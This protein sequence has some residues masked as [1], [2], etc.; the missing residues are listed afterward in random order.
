MYNNQI[1]IS[2]K[3]IHLVL[4]PYT[5]NQVWKFLI[6]HLYLFFSLPSLTGIKKLIKPTEIDKDHSIIH[7]FKSL[8]HFAADKMLQYK[9]IIMYSICIVKY[10]Q[11]AVHM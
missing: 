11:M 3:L 10:I 4:L 2:F 8:I 7:L 5:D 1:F 6:C 9:L